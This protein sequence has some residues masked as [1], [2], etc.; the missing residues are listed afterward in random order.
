MAAMVQPLPMIYLPVVLMFT[1]ISS[2]FAADGANLRVVE[3]VRDFSQLADT[4]NEKRLP[5][6]L[7]FSSDHCVFCERL[8]Q[9]FLIPMQISGDYEQRVV[10]RK[11]KMK[12]GNSVVDF[13]GQ[14]LDANL[15]AKRYNV[16]VTPTVVFL[17]GS[18]QQ[19]TAKHVGLMTPDFY[20]GYLDESIDIALDMLRRNKPLRVKLSAA[21]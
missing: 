18:G 21:E 12:Y 4:L 7:M 16:S 5:L 17:D 19:L 14:R 10:I 13:N 9:E 2:V 1:L 8:E 11:L 15:L 20:G 3:E 6:M